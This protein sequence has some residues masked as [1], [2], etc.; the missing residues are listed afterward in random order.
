MRKVTT[1]SATSGMAHWFS[2]RGAS[3]SLKSMIRGELA[4]EV[5]FDEA[6]VGAGEAAGWSEKWFGHPGE[7][8]RSA[9]D[10]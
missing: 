9:A 10:G 6:D 5:D 2:N 3:P 4:R 7:D 8:A 1:N